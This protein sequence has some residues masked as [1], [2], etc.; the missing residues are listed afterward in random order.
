MPDRPYEAYDTMAVYCHPSQLNDCLKDCNK[1]WENG[2][3]FVK[4]VVHYHQDR[5][6]I[7]V[8]MTDSYP[9]MK[10]N[11]MEKWGKYLETP[12][13]MDMRIRMQSGQKIT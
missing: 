10:T 5:F 12:D 13:D 6:I 2:R 7:I 8:C 1:L 4:D 9:F 3:F 11:L